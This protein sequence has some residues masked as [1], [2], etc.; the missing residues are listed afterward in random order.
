MTSAH[1]FHICPLYMWDHGLS[2]MWSCG[3]SVDETKQKPKAQ[4]VHQG[5]LSDMNVFVTG[6][7]QVRSMKGTWFSRMNYLN[8]LMPAK[9]RMPLLN[10]NV[11]IFQE[12]SLFL[13]HMV[14]LH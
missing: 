5:C 4:H 8:H 14:I 9:Y 6:N 13:M 2:S 10:E 11:H 1:T 7:S 12:V 3:S